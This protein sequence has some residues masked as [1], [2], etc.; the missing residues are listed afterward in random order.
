MPRVASSSSRI[1]SA[2]SLALTYCKPI[3]ILPGGAPLPHTAGDSPSA[4][5]LGAV[6]TRGLPRR[7]NAER[8][9]AMQA[10]LER[11]WAPRYGLTAINRRHTNTGSVP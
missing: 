5:E 6:L 11:G 2:R 4:S 3:L 1:P 10:T 8:T 9:R 7:R